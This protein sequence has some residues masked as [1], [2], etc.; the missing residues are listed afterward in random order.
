MVPFLE[1]LFHPV[2]SESKRLLSEKWDALSEEFRTPQQLYGRH[3]EGCGATIGAMPKCDFACRGCYLS[4][5]ANRIPASPIEDIK[6]QIRTLRAFLGPKG[7]LQL[8]DGEL[9]LRDTDDVI[10][11]IQYA[12]EV[13]LTPMLMTHGDTFRQD[14]TLL[15]RLVQEGGLRELSLHID[16][17]QRGRLGYK[18]AVNE[19]DL[20]PLRLE[21][22]E[23]IRSIRRDTG[24]SLRTASTVTVTRENLAEVGE[25]FRCLL[26]LS[27]VY[28]LVSFLPAAQVGRSQAGFGG[29]V[30]MEDIWREL[31]LESARDLQHHLWVQGHPECNTMI[32]GVSV[33][34]GHSPVRFLPLVS[35]GQ[36]PRE[37]F[38]R[39][40][41]QRFGGI[42][43]RDDT[44]RT[45]KLRATG[46]LLHAPKL[47]LWDGGRWLYA[48]IKH[49]YP[50]QRI[51]RLRQ[52]CRGDIKTRP[53]SVVVHQFMSREEVD[54]PLGQERL[55]HCTFKVPDGDRLI[56]MCEMNTLGHRERIYRT[57][58]DTY[59]PE[60][61]D[62]KPSPR[63]THT[64]DQPLDNPAFPERVHHNH[65]NP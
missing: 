27:D 37:E 46:L 26:D 49:L 47:M 7:N 17:T 35:G 3:Q 59:D 45:A 5:N 1:T 60:P 39:K 20:N 50:E 29:G 43:F 55:A 19:T 34:D 6:K 33:Q 48:Q 11:L 23:R 51:M 32:T 14:A 42:D 16:T 56:S 54:S 9:T 31:S 58:L 30:R 38:P 57:I 10:H 65:S 52:W 18:H 61:D 62:A 13:G 15:P 25:V 63:L 41:V 4:A 12:Y 22:A 21:F 28:H 8:T 2:P 53:F 64:T 40:F 36:S 24:I 44:S